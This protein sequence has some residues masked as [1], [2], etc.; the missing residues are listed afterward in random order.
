M[1][2]D[3]LFYISYFIFLVSF[4]SIF[5]TGLL[6]LGCF[7]GCFSDFFEHFDIDYSDIFGV[8]L[9]FGLISVLLLFPMMIFGFLGGAI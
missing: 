6:F 5:F 2:F 4:I 8:L 9:I 7:V 1:I 3:I